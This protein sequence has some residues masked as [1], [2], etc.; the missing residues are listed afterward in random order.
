MGVPLYMT[1]FFLLPLNCLF[2]FKFYHFNYGTFW[3]VSLSVHLVWDI[4]CLLYLDICFLLQV[5]EVFSHNFIKY[6]FDTFLSLFSFWSPYNANVSMLDV[7][8][9]VP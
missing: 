8:L 9:E 5:Q 6:I 4:L 1:V 3:C 2:V 7:V